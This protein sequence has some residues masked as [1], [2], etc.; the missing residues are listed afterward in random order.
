M[1]ILKQ[2]ESGVPVPDLCREHGMSS[3][4]LYSWRSKYEGMD[5]SLISQM[6][7]LA[8][9]NAHI[10]RMYVEVSMQNDLLKDALKKSD[11]GV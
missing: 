1:Q 11:S 5:A 4:T 6:K 10:K 3:A 7:A 8:A 2:A 9:E